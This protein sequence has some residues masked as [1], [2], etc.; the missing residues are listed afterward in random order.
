MDMYGIVLCE[1]L[2]FAPLGGHYDGTTISS[3]TELT[4]PDG[5][6]KLMIQA[7]DKNVRI[8][9]D[10]TTPTAT[11]GFRLTA[12]DPPMIIPISVLTIVK[13]IQEAATADIQ[14]QWGK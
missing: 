11:C 14:Y 13:V 2:Q 7:L 3:A 8:T 1:D 12:G 10:G 6:K 4:P 9:L 5:A